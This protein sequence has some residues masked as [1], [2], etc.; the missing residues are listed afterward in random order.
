MAK[1][2]NGGFMMSKINQVA[3]RVF[4]RL[5]KEY[6]ITEI[7]P[8]QGRILF[9]LWEKD[10]IPITELSEKT[11]LDKST[12]TSMLDRLEESGYLRRVP[13]KDD[14]RKIMIERTEKDHAFQKAYIEVSDEMNRIF[15]EGLS[16]TEIDGF[17]GNLAKILEN[18]VRADR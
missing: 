3:G 14:R 16:E 18:L 6:N 1:A 7:N 5:L 4:S 9:V 8:A 13:S 2:R 15:Y 17:E 10:G 11:M 12:L